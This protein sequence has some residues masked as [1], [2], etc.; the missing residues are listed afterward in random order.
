MIDHV[1]Y[2]VLAH[3]A[4]TTRTPEEA[5]EVL[6][7]LPEHDLALSTVL[8]RGF[9]EY[10]PSF[11]IK[12][13]HARLL[14]FY[15]SHILL[16]NLFETLGAAG[17]L[18]SVP[19]LDILWRLAGPTSP[20][21]LEWSANT[22]NGFIAQAIANDHVHVLDWFSR[23][24][25]TANVS[26]QWE[27]QSWKLAVP[28]VQLWAIERGYL[29]EI[30][31]SSALF[32]I[33]DDNASIMEWWIAQ[34]PSREE[35]MAALSNVELVQA[36]STTET[37]NWWWANARSGGLPD[38]ESF[39]IITCVVLFNGNMDLIEWWW[40]RFLEHRTPEHTF[41]S[42]RN[43][44]EIYRQRHIAAMEWLWEHSHVSGTNYDLTAFPFFPPDWHG[45][46]LHLIF[47]IYSPKS[48]RFLQWAVAK[49]TVL[50][51]RLHLNSHVV[52][53]WIS[54]G[55]VKELDWV[56]NLRD[57][58][59]VDWPS[60]IATKA[61]AFGQLAPMEWWRCHQD[62]LP[63]QDLDCTYRLVGAVKVDAVAV[64]VWWY[65]H[66]KQMS[67]AN[68]QE[69]C[70][71]AIKYNA[72]RVQ[73]WL[74]EIAHQFVLA[75]NQADGFY[76]KV[77]SPEMTRVAPVTLDFM[78]A[79]VPSSLGSVESLPPP[80][81][82]LVYSCLAALHWYCNSNNLMISSLLPLELSTWKMLFRHANTVILEWWLQVH[83][84]AGH[85]VVLLEDVEAH[86][87]VH[88]VAGSRRWVLD[89]AV[90]R[91]IP[92]YVGSEERSTQ[93]GQPFFMMLQK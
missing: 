47:S 54:R 39:S 57:T 2:I 75:D 3:A 76:A 87:L 13:G 27:T 64:I 23:V 70:L 49:C 71:F 59:E 78:A 33:R 48:L 60:D 63:L 26:P 82:S 35:A 93:L 45:I 90:T 67:Q 5:I 53:V 11:A 58:L 92:L 77:W 81:P 65:T 12:H 10:Q 80:P 15:P 74:L 38:P 25:S 68:W 84:A 40:A 34:Q 17:T 62:Q 22:R 8:S 31:G 19:V 18:G 51:Q 72:S 29:T 28:R 66:Q 83:L 30:D 56:F 85:H 69:L 91:N 46:L 79:I 50:G 44:T 16:D 36:I 37:L 4:G 88:R 89:V 7:V 20:G 6:N 24:A 32:S 86:A 52:N 1:L 9:I 73:R 43:A 61:V 14:P 21:R 42:Q 41:G 55:D